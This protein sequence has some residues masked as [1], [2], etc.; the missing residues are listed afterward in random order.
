MFQKF[1]IASYCG[2]VYMDSFENLRCVI[3]HDVRFVFPEEENGHLVTTIGGHKFV[4]ALG[5][6]V[7][8]K[9]FYGTMK[10]HSDTVTIVDSSPELFRLFIACFYK[11]VD[12]SRLNVTSLVEFY[13]I[14]DKYDVQELKVN[15]VN[16]NIMSY[17]KLAFYRR[18]WLL[19]SS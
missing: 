5:S 9:Q 15:G 10:D 3:N 2:W 8:K 1:T 7:F 13:H 6:S 11:S 19:K 17:F 18:T 4:L 16:E 14:A 12:I